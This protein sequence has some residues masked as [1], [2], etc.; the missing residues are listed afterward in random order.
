MAGW[1]CGEY[2]CMEQYLY[3]IAV[4]RTNWYRNLDRTHMMM[5]I[6]DRKR[7]IRAEA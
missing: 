4:D 2:L 6:D 5:M 7:V 3:R 1:L